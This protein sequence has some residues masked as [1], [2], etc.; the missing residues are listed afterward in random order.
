MSPF[1]LI[2]LTLDARTGS[3]ISSTVMRDPYQS[4]KECMLVAIDQGPRKSVNGRAS[5]MVCQAAGSRYSQAL[6]P[7]EKLLQDG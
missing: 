1:L 2:L 3:L 5:L 6:P 4:F 7:P